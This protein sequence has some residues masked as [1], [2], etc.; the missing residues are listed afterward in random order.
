VSVS[1]SMYQTRGLVV[2]DLLASSGAGAGLRLRPRSDS[3]GGTGIRGGE[4]SGRTRAAAASGGLLYEVEDLSRHDVVNL[5]DLRGYLELGRS[6]RVCAGAD[7]SAGGYPTHAAAHQHGGHTEQLACTTEIWLHTETIEVAVNPYRTPALNLGGAAGRETCVTRSACV[8]VVDI[9]GGAGDGA[10]STPPMFALNQC[11][12]QLVSEEQ[13]A[14]PPDWRGSA[15]TKLMKGPLTGEGRLAILV[16][17]GPTGAQVE[18]SMTALRLAA[19]ARRLPG[20]C[21]DSS[22][23]G[24]LGDGIGGVVDSSGGR[25]LIRRTMQP[26]ETTRREQLAANLDRVKKEARAAVGASAARGGSSLAPRGQSVRP[27]SAV[28]V[29]SVPLRI[30]KEQGK[31]P[32]A[33]DHPLRQSGR[34]M[35]GAAFF[36]GSGGSA[37]GGGGHSVLHKES[38]VK[39]VSEYDRAGIN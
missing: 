11:V 35:S 16:A 20:H 18:E 32:D 23:F 26:P 27:A 5:N 13:H 12:R 39:V 34:S 38:P 33:V 21:G 14:V 9:A 1:V 22:V 17:T 2:D 15:L 25:R 8:R 7:T 19:A 29:G 4:G 30:S 36:V 31:T 3:S 24:S 10:G 6:R 37:R 28:A